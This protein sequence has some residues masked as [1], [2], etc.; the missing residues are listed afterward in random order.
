MILNHS[1]ATSQVH[2]KGVYP[3][4]ELRLLARLIA[5]AHLKKGVHKGGRSKTS[6]YLQ[7]KK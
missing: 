5:N 4:A 3:E 6:R 2:D 1:K 7:K